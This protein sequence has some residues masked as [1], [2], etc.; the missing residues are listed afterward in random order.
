MM[1]WSSKSTKTQCL[2]NWKLK[3]NEKHILNNKLRQSQKRNLKLNDSLNTIRTI[4]NL[5]LTQKRTWTMFLNR[6]KIDKTKST[7]LKPFEFRFSDHDLRTYNKFKSFSLVMMKLESSEMKLR[8]KW[9]HLWAKL[10]RLIIP[11]DMFISY[12]KE[13]NK[14]TY[15][16]SKD[17]WLIILKLETQR[18]TFYL[19]QL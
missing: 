6:L 14:K 3:R 11:S 15:L 2:K 4:P 18:S 19:T 10:K 7:D 9:K 13:S 8:N 1:I 12:Y 5:C 17:C 16:G